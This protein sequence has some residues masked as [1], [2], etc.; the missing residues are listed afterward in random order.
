MTF[1]RLGPSAKTTPMASRM[2]GMARNTSTTRMMIA[3]ARP[4]KKPASKPNV[5]PMHADSITEETP[6]P[7]EIRPP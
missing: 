6:T 1:S 2:Y 3:S 7:S 5:T 4:P